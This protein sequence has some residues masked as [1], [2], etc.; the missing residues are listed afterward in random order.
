LVGTGLGIAQSSTRT[1]TGESSDHT[2]AKLK[3]TSTSKFSNFLCSPAKLKYT[4][5]FI[6]FIVGALGI[7]TGPCKIKIH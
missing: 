2:V 5:F 6:I 7:A 1:Y 4:N 3:M